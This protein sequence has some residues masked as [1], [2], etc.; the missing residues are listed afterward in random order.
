MSISESS[1]VSFVL[2]ARPLER[3]LLEFS[4]PN[5]NELL[6][7]PNPS[8]NREV[9][10]TRG[11]GPLVA[12]DMGDRNGRA[13]ETAGT[14]CTGMAMRKPRLVNGFAVPSS[15]RGNLT[16]ESVIEG[17]ERWITEKDDCLIRG[18]V[19]TEPKVGAGLTGRDEP[20]PRIPAVQDD[21]P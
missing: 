4:V 5:V 20:L 13:G 1:D 3:D 15:E 2:C 12:P 6:R 19:I 7:D 16:G 18:V 21:Q 11:R 14:T 17:E 10:D 9:D 8:A